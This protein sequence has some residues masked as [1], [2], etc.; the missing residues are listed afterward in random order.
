VVIVVIIVLIITYSKLNPEN[1]H[2]FPQCPFK[3]LTGFEC[4]GCGSQRAM[5]HLL[6]L[7]ISHA[8]QENALLVFSIP[9]I[10]LLLSATFL[11]SRSAGFMRLH[12][13]LYGIKAIWIVC[14]IIV[15]WWIARN[16]LPI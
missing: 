2:F 11:K 8:I 15:L 13:V 4:P 7:K 9:Y 3:L 5:H 12:N 10:L 1:S 16:F 6:N 14:S